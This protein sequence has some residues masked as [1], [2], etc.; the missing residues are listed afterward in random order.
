MEFLFLIGTLSFTVSGYLVG[1]KKQFDLLG[2]I[3]LALLTAIGGG[4][5]R[6]MLLNRIPSLFMDATPL[7]SVFA[8]LAIAWMIRAHRITSL[9]LNRL[10]I[11]ADSIGLVAFSIAGARIALDFQLGSFGTIA[12]AFIN[13]VGG[14]LIRDMLVNDVPFILHRDFYGTVAI[15]AALGVMA[16]DHFQTANSTGLY[17]VFLTGLVLRLVA[18][19]QD[20]QL[21]RHR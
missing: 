16:L 11:V 14:G 18:H 5:I 10:F 1:V 20:F 4:I 2:I 15:L 17:A 8:A 12:I 7:W 6:D 9:W 13:A 3:I 21:P 19:Y